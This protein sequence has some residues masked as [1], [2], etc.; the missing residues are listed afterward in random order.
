MYLDAF[1]R[2]GG[3]GGIEWWPNDPIKYYEK[4]FA[5][6]ILPFLP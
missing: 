6:I 4:A 1:A 2:G 5:L 3:G